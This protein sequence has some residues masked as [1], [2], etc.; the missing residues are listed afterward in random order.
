MGSGGLELVDKLMES[1]LSKSKIAKQGLEDMRLLLRYC[2]LYKCSEN[3]TFDLSLA[4]GLDYYTGV[5]IGIERL[6]SIMEANM[7]KN[8]TKV[9]TVET[10]VCVIS[11]QKNLAEE[12]MKIIA[13]L[14]EA[15]I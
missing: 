5:I 12:R 8:K 6:F 14:W 11:A 15:G 2:E 4:R 3:L 9:R 7:T 1:D 13:D 10:Q